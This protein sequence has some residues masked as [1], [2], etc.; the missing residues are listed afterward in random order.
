[1]GFSDLLTSSRGPGVIGTLLALLVLVGFG[2]LY[3]FVFDEGLQGGKQTIESVIRAQT[4]D[5]ESTKI[6]IE[7]AK[8]RLEEADVA[9]AKAREADAQATLNAA[10]VKQIEE[11]TASK[12]AAAAEI[13]KAE[14]A[15]EAYKDEYRKSEWAS[16]IGEKM[17]DIKTPSGQVFTDVEVKGVDH[18]GVRISHS[19]GSKTIA[20]EDLPPDLYDRLQ[21]DLAKKEAVEKEKDTIEGSLH[22]DVELTN[23]LT[24]NQAKQA[25][26]DASNQEIATLS[27]AVEKA[28][29]AGPRYQLA[30]ATKRDQIA[31]EK[32]KIGGVSRAPA[33]QDELK[34]M[35][36]VAR[37][38]GDSIP[39]NEK[40]ISTARSEITKL[41]GEI[42]ENK[43]K[44]D[45]IKKKA[46]SAAPKN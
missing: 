27:A 6:Q 19:A 29:E 9:K 39:V 24:S 15:W 22:N 37:E 7:N 17:A 30:M 41:Q 18:T 3:L 26:I 13:P 16:A 33:M 32:A 14:A 20:P 28:K 21:F 45:E 10:L 23:L 4:G 12:E 40:K 38:T 31:S 5:I 35:E 36:K 34:A 2:T 25:K 44:I 1:M 43:A 46:Q 11:L 42:R 8:K